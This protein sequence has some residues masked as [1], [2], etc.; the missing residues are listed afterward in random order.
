M[1]RKST[2]YLG[3]GIGSVAG[4]Y[5]PTLWGAGA[6]S[7]TSILLSTVGGLLGIWLAFRLTA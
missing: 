6:F 3:G 7:G 2:L 4:G 5:L 1:S